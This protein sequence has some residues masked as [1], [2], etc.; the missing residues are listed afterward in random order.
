MG[1]RRCTKYDRIFSAV[2]CFSHVYC[3]DIFEISLPHA[4]QVVALVATFV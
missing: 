4:E 3:N 2:L 1:K